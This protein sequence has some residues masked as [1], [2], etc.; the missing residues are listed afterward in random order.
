MIPIDRFRLKET[1]CLTRKDRLE[2][3]AMRG[4]MLKKKQ[5]AVAWRTLM[6]QM[7]N[8]SGPGPTPKFNDLVLRIYSSAWKGNRS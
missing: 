2:A 8:A 7:L 3:I 4:L 1:E 5:S 6:E